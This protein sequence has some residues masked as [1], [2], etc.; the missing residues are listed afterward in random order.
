MTDQ[1][2]MK[3]YIEVMKQ[4]RLRDYLLP[5]PFL[6]LFLNGLFFYS[7]ISYGYTSLRDLFNTLSFTAFSIIWIFFYPYALYVIAETKLYKKVFRS[8]SI[9]E[10]FALLIERIHIMKNITPPRYIRERTTTY[11][12]N[13]GIHTNDRYF[14]RED[15][16][17]HQAKVL[18]Y[19]IF[20]VKDIFLRFFVHV[21]IIFLFSPLIFLVSVPFL[22]RLPKAHQQKK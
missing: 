16:R 7:N 9:I 2:T 14:E 17:L 22:H 12:K 13:G 1:A 6:L 8:S 3:Q 11:Y 15:E 5:L 10:S 19:A 20:V 18:S 4:F 21:G